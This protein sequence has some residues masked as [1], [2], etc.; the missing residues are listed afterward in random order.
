MP[1]LIKLFSIILNETGHMN[2]SG[3][4]SVI[5]KFTPVTGHINDQLICNKHS[6]CSK[7]QQLR[8]N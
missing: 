7:Q 8:L 5:R 4:D 3:N 2:F 6:S 1:T